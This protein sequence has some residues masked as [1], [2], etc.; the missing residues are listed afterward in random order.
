MLAPV[1]KGLCGVLRLIELPQAR[2][3]AD[4]RAPGGQMLQ[5]GDRVLNGRNDCDK[6]VF[7]GEIGVITRI[8]AEDD[9]NPGSVHVYF[10]GYGRSVT[11]TAAKLGALSSGP[12]ADGGQGPGGGI[13][14]CGGA[15]FEPPDHAGAPDLPPGA[16]G[17][18]P[19][20]RYRG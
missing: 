1:K 15:V 13:S 2:D 20:G 5:V 14:G 4:I 11:W 9:D 3:K 8:D 6:E 10:D 18:A 17:C 7:N 19:G 12:G 16:H